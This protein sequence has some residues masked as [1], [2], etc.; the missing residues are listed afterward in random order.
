MSKSVTGMNKTQTVAF[1]LALILSSYVWAQF[2]LSTMLGPMVFGGGPL[3]ATDLFAILPWLALFGFPW[4]SKR[5]KIKQ[6][7]K[8]ALG[9]AVLSFALAALTIFSI[10]YII[11][12]GNAPIETENGRRAYITH[13]AGNEYHIPTGYSGMLAENTKD[14]LLKAA[15]PDMHEI[16]RGSP[17]AAEFDKH[18]GEEASIHIQ[19]AQST[20]SFQFRFGVAKEWYSPLRKEGGQ[21]GLSHFVSQKGPSGGIVNEAFLK[22][23]RTMLRDSTLNYDS[24]LYEELYMEPDADKPTTYIDCSGDQSAPHPM[25]EE[26]FEDKGRLINVLFTKKRLADWK[27]IKE[28][29]IGLLDSFIKK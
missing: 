22:S 2:C 16:I 21:Y 25:C 23:V 11:T 9:I 7:P 17:E 1:Y 29:T 5:M 10:N 8:L 6:R 13:L 14:I 24:L 26:Y 3:R 27:A 19:D 20:T 12:K 15:F 18:P 28:A 4:M